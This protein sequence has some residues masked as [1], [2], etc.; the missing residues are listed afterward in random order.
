MFA[1]FTSLPTFITQ[2]AY[3]R[4]LIR[5]SKINFL[6]FYIAFHRVTLRIVAIKYASREFEHVVSAEN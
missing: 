6:A 1:E 3:F 4:R 2:Y 5:L